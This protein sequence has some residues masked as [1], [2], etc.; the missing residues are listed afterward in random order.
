MQRKPDAEVIDQK[1]RYLRI[2]AGW[3]ALQLLVLDSEVL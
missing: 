2:F 1:T 3:L